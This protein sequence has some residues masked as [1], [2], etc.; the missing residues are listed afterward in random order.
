MNSPFRLGSFFNSLQVRYN[1]GNVLVSE[2][3]TSIIKQFL[4]YA[5]P[6]CLG[7]I[8]LP[9]LTLVDIFTMP[10]LLKSGGL[11]ESASMHL[12]GIY[13]HGL[14]LVQLIAMIATS[15][16]VALVPSIA[17]AKLQHNDYVIRTQTE[18]AIRMTWLIGLAAS[19]GMATAAI[20][21][22]VM[23]YN[24]AEGWE[25]ISILAFT[26]VLSA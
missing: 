23:F 5:L 13:N 1:K 17:K 3:A 9:I 11:A 18:Q 20:P 6:I 15:M 10:R 25:V 4:R 16:S 12:F 26:A 14:P 7:T 8:V 2:K 22:N 19:F 21:L 24:S